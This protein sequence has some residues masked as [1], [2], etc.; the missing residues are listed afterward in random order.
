MGDRSWRA[1]WRL[2]CGLVA[3]AA[4]LGLTPTR[5]RAADAA[6]LVALEWVAPDGCPDGAYV[7]SQVRRFVADA[8]VAG[9]PYLRARAEVLQEESGLWR[10]E[11]RTTGSQGSGAR[12]VSAESCRALA[13]ATALI[14]ALA[15]DPEHAVANGST[16]SSASQAST[17]P[18]TG[19][20]ATG[21]KSA[22]IPASTSPFPVRLAAGAS[23]V[24]DVGTLPKAAPGVTAR[25]AAVPRAFSALRLEI[26]ASLFLDEATTSPPARSGTFSLR[27]FDAGGCIVTPTRSLEWGAC[28]GAE[29]AWLAATGLHESVPSHGEAA[30][31]VLRARATVAYSW[32]SAC[33]IRAEVGG[34]VDLSRPEF[35]SAG[36][37]QG[38]IYQP[39]RYT[40]R[41]ALG[42]EV[43]F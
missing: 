33:A 29:V 35:V 20:A 38:L 2:Q 13:D 34:G 1:R 7:E 43:R 10:V 37:G 42:F 9:G 3:L 6:A 17:Q 30:W 28:A 41:G 36:A 39:A 14:L 31:P 11:L 22:L 25:L 32:S 5:A 27:A 19:D 8:N 18:A 21:P 16:R 15:L 12:S 24:L 4:A 23:A 40:A 26:G